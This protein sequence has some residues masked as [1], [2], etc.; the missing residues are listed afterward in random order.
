MNQILFLQKSTAVR[1]CIFT[2]TML[3][4][5]AVPVS[6][7]YTGDISGIFPGFARILLS[8]S[9]LV[10]DYFELG[11]LTASFL[12]AE[13]CCLTCWAIIYF[14]HALVTSITFAG[15][16]LVAAHY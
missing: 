15:W 5:A 3:L 8:P 11:G 1:R 2:F 16:F 12:N 7:L 13:L 14:S 6:A 9:P 10:T 4:L